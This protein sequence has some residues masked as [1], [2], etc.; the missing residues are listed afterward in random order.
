MNEL[1]TMLS[2]ALKHELGDSRRTIKTVMNWT[3][4][5]ERTAKNW[6]AGV[7]GPSGQHLIELA[8]NSDEV[9]ELVLLLSERRPVLT[10]VSLL[11]IRNHLAGA[12]DQLDR[13]LV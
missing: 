5:S 8:K 4:A 6:L 10:T 12:I 1:S 3:G 2:V 11:R 9:F 7:H 13:H